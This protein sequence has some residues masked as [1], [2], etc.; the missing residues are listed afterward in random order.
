MPKEKS[1]A[2]FQESLSETGRYQLL[3][4]AIRD[5]AIYM[6]D[7]A[8]IITNWNPGAERFKGYSAGEIIGEHFSR[9]YTE[10][11]QAADLPRRVL[12]IA[13]KEGKFEAEGWR[14]RK[15][16]S[17]FWAHVVV[18]SVRDAEGQLIGFAKITRDLT[19]RRETQLALEKAKEALFQSQKMEAIGR[20]TGG[21]AHDFNNLLAAISGSL[22]LIKK[23][24]TDDRSLSY[25]ET[26][27][28]AVKRGAALTQRM[29]VFAR[30]HELKA[31]RIDVP[32]LVNGM[33]DLLQRFVGPGTTIETRFP[34][35]LPTILADTNQFESALLNLVVNARDAMHEHGVITIGARPETGKE[36]GKLTPG[37]YVCIYVTDTGEGMD[38]DVIA[39]AAEPFFTT[40]GVGKGTGLGLSMV[41]GFVEESGGRMTIESKKGAGTTVELCFPAA[42]H[43]A[44]A[45]REKQAEALVNA[46]ERLHVLAVDD[47]V[48]VLMNLAAMLEDLGHRVD[49]ASCGSDALEMLKSNPDIQLLITDQAMP[50]MTGLMLAESARK[51]RPDLPVILATG[52]ADLPDRAHGYLKLDK[53]YFQSDLTHA[54]G[55]AMAHARR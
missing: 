21:I 51:E 18:D 14:V 33:A 27:S 6:L 45:P 9:F 43:A 37:H 31:E 7:P 34:L 42:P 3:V 10:E 29:L 11:D 25:I 38:A 50:K 46:P 55:N 41:Q 22:E 2:N 19:E 44:P 47:D 49:Q 5:Y 35:R 20:L 8:G 26:A 28:Q 52:Y 48:L 36:G 1:S 39:H 54:I 13:E 17:Q 40:K 4:G 12:E 32:A 30:R 23:R 15:D 16:G 53:P 24:A